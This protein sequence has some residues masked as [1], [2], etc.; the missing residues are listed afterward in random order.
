MFIWIAI[1]I[2]IVVISILKFSKNQPNKE[3][4]LIAILCIDRDSQLI[5][6]QY[7]SIRHL[8]TNP[9]YDLLVMTRDCDLQTQLKWRSKNIRVWIIPCYKIKERHNMSALVKQRNMIREY[10]QDSHYDN[11]L[12]LDS[13]IIINKDTLSRLL[14]TP[15]DVALVPYKVKWLGYPAIGNYDSSENLIIE[16]VQPSTDQYKPCIIGGMGCTLLRQKALSIPFEYKEI[17]SDLYDVVGEDIGFFL[18]LHEAGLK[19][20]YVTNHSIL[21]L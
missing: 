13:D 5:D 2:F 3:R 11:L 14:N 4:I 10:A 20:N 15:G 9:N 12:F 6:R 8:L 19:A 1:L 21:H 7:N 18:N 17:P 16:E